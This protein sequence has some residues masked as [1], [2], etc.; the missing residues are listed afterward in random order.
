EDEQTT[1]MALPALE[2]GEHCRI[3]G[4]ELKD[5]MTSPPAPFTEGTLIAAMKNAASQV[6]DPKL[7]KVL[8]EN[9]GL[10]TE[11]TRAGV[12]E[13]LFAR[14]YLEK[15]GKHIRSTQRGRELTAAL[16]EALTSPGMTAL[17][18]Q[19]LDDIAQGR[20][21]LDT[22]MGR[23][24]QWVRHLVSS[25]REQPFSMT[26]PVTPPCPLCQGPTR[27]RKGK[28]GLF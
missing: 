27:Q 22:F 11:A 25:G 9:A 8:R 16:P 13:V 19:A 23:Q 3:S 4:S 18:E 21:S 20:M 10:G 1:E 28:H 12:L 6:S 15:S 17:W 2:R 14:Q 7:K 5:R 24:Q 26:V